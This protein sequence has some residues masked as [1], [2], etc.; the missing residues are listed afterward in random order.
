ME[1]GC[2][3]EHLTHSF[4]KEIHSLLADYKYEIREIPKD[5]LDEFMMQ[6]DFRAINVTIPYKQ[7][8]IPHLFWVSETAQKIGA[9]NTIVNRDGKLYG[10]NTDFYGLTALINKNDISLAQKK[11]LI[12][13]SGGTSKTANAVAEHLGAKEI[14]TVSRKS[15]KGLI[16]Y[17]EMYDNH[18]DADVIINTT[19]VGMFPNIN[20]QPVELNRFSLLSGVVDAIYNPLRSRLVLEA[21]SLGIRATGGLYMLV[22]QAAFAVEKFIGAPLCEE[23]I[24]EVYNSLV[25]QK[26]NIVL[27][28]MP[29]C[30]KST[31]GA[32][33][34][35]ITG[36]PFIDT[37]KLIV[38][39][40]GKPITEI[41]KEI[42]EEGFRKLEG[43]VIADI[44]NIGGHIIA[45]GGGAVLSQENIKNL[46]ANGRI[47]YIDRPLDWLGATSDR[48]LSSNR[49]DLAKRY[50]ERYEIY[51]TTADVTVAAVDDLESNIN[52]ILKS[53]DGET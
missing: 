28:G 32:K 26:I 12:L 3:G 19:P 29:A 20:A 30:G 50:F 23:K 2:I 27:T 17:E 36:K 8:V 45:T 14:Y 51:K 6:R 46:K 18:T 47:Y 21:E 9:V 38:K 40:A 34:S 22:A 53:M 16:T 24:S 10:Y 48:P 13:G 49:E 1:Y 52:L 25:S 11:V 4:S 42:G 43:E 41:F 35:R 39:R 44:G 33:L 15:D 31:I 5:K 37:D 7:A